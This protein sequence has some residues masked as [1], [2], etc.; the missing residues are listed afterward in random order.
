MADNKQEEVIVDVEKV[1]SKSE[2]F[3]EKNNKKISIVVGAIVGVVALY[4][5]YQNLYIAPKEKEA[6]EMMW[7]AEYYFEIDSLDL[8]INGDGNYFG[9]DYIANNY[10][11]TKS[12]ELA[13]YYLGVSYFKKGDYQSAISY[14]KDVSI[15]D[16]IVSSIALGTIGDAYVELEDYNN[17][18]KYF[19]QAANNSKNQFST[20]LYLK[21][22]AILHENLGE[23]AKAKECYETIST[24]Y[25]ESTEGQDIEKY[26]ARVQNYL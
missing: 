13:E 16:E 23:Y 6:T 14:L 17:G 1:Y 12:G 2:E 7:K 20:P 10:S 22:K 5:A 4:F 9:F 19:G 3:F 11:G 21:K 18:L 15:D 8:A 25:P 24:D 26:L